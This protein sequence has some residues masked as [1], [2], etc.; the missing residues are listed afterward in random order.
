MATTMALVALV[1]WAM[2]VVP[3]MA[4]GAMVVMDMTTFVCPFLWKISVLWILLKKLISRQ[5]SE[6]FEYLWSNHMIF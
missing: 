6:Y 4:L 3:A 2:A 1:A 5:N